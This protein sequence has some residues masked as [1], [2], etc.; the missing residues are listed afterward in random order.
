MNKQ[1]ID[2]HEYI[3]TFYRRK[4]DLLQAMNDGA[5]TAADNFYRI[6]KEPAVKSLGEVVFVEAFKLALTVVPGAAFASKTWLA[7]ASAR[8]VFA[9]R[10]QFMVGTM[11]STGQ[12]AHQIATQAK[13]T[14][15]PLNKTLPGMLKKKMDEIYQRLDRG[16]AALERE[17][18]AMEEYLT[19]CV[20]GPAY[21]QVIKNM[22][23]P[24]DP[25]LNANQRKAIRSNFELQLFKAYVSKEVKIIEIHNTAWGHMSSS[26]HGVNNV[27]QDYIR[28]E[29]GINNHNDW[30]KKLGAKVEK[31]TVRP[32]HGRD[33]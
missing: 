16:F 22:L 5:N 11:I 9:A 20:A 7:L 8:P 31:Q 4:K 6:M 13:T 21:L 33:Y 17:H 14:S 27:Q 18:A 19:N 28:Q 29:F 32:S 23:G 12:S 10:T 2:A 26:I 30:V 25:V 15:T 3:D 24:H 1:Y